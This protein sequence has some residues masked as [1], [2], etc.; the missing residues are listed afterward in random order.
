VKT[1]F[2]L[3][4]SAFSLLIVSIPACAHHGVSGYDLQKIVT[5]K[6]TVAGFEWSNPH[7]VA[8]IAVENEKGEP[9]EWIVE[10]GAPGIMARSGWSR[11]S[12]KP[13]DQVVAETHP[14]KN[15]ATSGL[16]AT[17]TI[18]LRFVV[19]GQPLASK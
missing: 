2:I 15:G 7:C 13:G 3:L 5:L 11:N 16:S 1:T 8:H 17:S 10:L 9:E 12:L 6:G 19:N 4:A 18:L 14:A